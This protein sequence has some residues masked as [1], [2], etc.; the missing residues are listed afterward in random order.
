[1][2]FNE[3]MVGLLV[4]L[5]AAA[6]IGLEREQ[7][8]TVDEKQHIGGIWTFPLLAVVGGLSAL[9]GHVFGVW[10][11]LGSL[12]IVGVFLAAASV[13]GR[14]DGGASDLP[15]EVAALI[16]FLLGVLAVLPG[17][18]LPVE[19]WYLVIVASAAIVMGLLSSGE[20]FV[21]VL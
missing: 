4:A 10:P 17:I 5:G 21:T 7:S 2:T 8:R 16:T 3:I 13:Q 20:P 12:V 15:T 9:A 1:M 11:I 14:I 19:Q 18:P 6:L